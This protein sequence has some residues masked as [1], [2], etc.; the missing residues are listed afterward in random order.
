MSYMEKYRICQSDISLHVDKVAWKRS[1][2]KDRKALEDAVRDL[3]LEK[4]IEM[5]TEIQMREMTELFFDEKQEFL[6]KLGHKTWIDGKELYEYAKDTYK[7][8]KWKIDECNFHPVC[9]M[10]GSHIAQMNTFVMKRL[11]GKREGNKDE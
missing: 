3:S 6:L 2:F 10:S 4:K 1:G 7:D 9:V 11:K 5:L 8:D